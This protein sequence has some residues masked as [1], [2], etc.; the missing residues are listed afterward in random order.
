MICEKKGVGCPGDPATFRS[1]IA[2]SSR[3]LN[4]HRNSSY[5]RDF[6]FDLAQAYETWW[7][8]SQASRDDDY[9][10]AEKFTEGADLA[11]GRAIELYQQ[12]VHE[13]PKSDVAAYAM[14][15]LPR[16]QSKLDTSQR[17]YY[18]IYD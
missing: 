3:F 12:V 18:C 7:S 13:A 17:Q 4:R 16:L 1:V 11:R 6:L 9:V 10:N 14:L 8:L 2:E 5:R 15:V